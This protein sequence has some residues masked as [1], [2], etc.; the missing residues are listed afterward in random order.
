MYNNRDISWLGFNHRVLLEAGN[1]NVPLMERVR[2]LSIFSSN[3]DEFFRV[4]FP[5]IN[6]YS[7]LEPKLRGR[8]I[9]PPDDALSE[10]VQQ[11]IDGH[12][13]D[14]GRIINNEVLPDLE[15]ENIILY[16]N[17]DIPEE[18]GNELKEFFYARIL[19][20]IQPVIIR[21]SLSGDF[22]PESNKLYLLVSLCRE[23][24]D[25][26]THA[27]LN[28]P[29]GNV[30]RF[31]SIY[32]DGKQHIFFID[33]IIRQNL[34]YIFNGFTIKSC[35]SFKITR[36]ADLDLDEETYKGN[37]LQEIEKKLQERE[38]GAP[39]RLLYQA[40][41]PF[42]M[43]KLMA[44][45][46]GLN[47]K[48]LFEGGI[49]H[50]L[51]DLAN[52][53]V[54]REELNYPKMVSLKH[55][56]LN[57][58]GDMFKQME[59]KDLLLHFPYHSYNPVLSFFSQAA[60]DPDVKS[61]Y[62]TLYRVAS[63]SLIVNALISAAKNKKNVTVFVELKARFDEANN[64][65][66]SREMK[67][68]GVQIIYNIPGIK[69]H[70]KIA[71][72]KKKRSSGDISYAFIGSGNFNESTARFYTDHALFT[73]HAGIT[74]DLT[75]LFSAL[76]KEMVPVKSS[77]KK[78][79]HLLVTQNNMLDELEKQINRQ[80]KRHNKGLPSAIKIKVNNLEDIGMINLLYKA[81]QVGIKIQLL[82]RSVC[83]IIPGK[84]GL[85]ENI[86]VKR[87]VDRYLEHSRIFIFGTG[88]ERA[89]FMGSADLM[90]RNLYKR[91]EV[92]TPVFDNEIASELEHYFDIQWNDTVKAVTLGE[93]AEQLHLPAPSSNGQDSE[94]RS[95]QQNIY[96]YLNTAV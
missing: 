8:I 4:R 94:L 19:S 1:N 88:E 54:N 47:D 16:Y 85:S 69:V 34:G 68:A 20:F 39:T 96:T 67:K 46:F 55:K 41:M 11:I 23:G 30:G 50:N 72:I 57:D 36:D 83:C 24:E 32:K 26:L 52:L 27:F 80:I 38:N 17:R 5:L 62:V 76:E 21:K 25:K 87:I 75:V 45:S 10:K 29:S 64:I 40:G 74:K 70:S 63:D 81:S 61:I 3:L 79:E 49:Y 9:P 92:I 86:Q 66:W 73:T 37:M 28:I 71:L 51:F 58:Y 78:F 44:A 13:N 93:H 77:G 35:C 65:H 84:T 42:S 91:V 43:Q 14:Y 82:V 53:P 60:I 18:F 31:H 48:Q 22:F 12:L 33:D 90:T 89:V 7:D 56:H 6:V 95:A 59:E 2:F 15:K